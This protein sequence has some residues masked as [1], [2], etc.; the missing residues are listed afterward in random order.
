MKKL[1]FLLLF[2]PS[3]EK[4]TP[5]YCWDCILNTASLTGLPGTNWTYGTSQV[6]YCDKTQE[7]ID[8]ICYDH[9]AQGN[10]YRSNME[11]TKRK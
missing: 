2:F 5:H 11:C 10:H 8:K 4:G 6:K 3:C 7:E 1:L 9:F